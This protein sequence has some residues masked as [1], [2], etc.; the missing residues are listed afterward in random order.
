M[1]LIERLNQA[2]D[3][4]YDSKNAEINE[5]LTLPLD[6]RVA[7]GDSIADV[8]AEFIPTYIDQGTNRIHFNRVIVKCSRNISKYREGSPVVLSGHGCSFNLDVIEDNNE[9]MTLA[10]G[11]NFNSIQ[12]SLN[13]KSGW[14]IDNAK[15]DIRHIV[16]KATDILRFNTRTLDYISGIFSGKIIF[17]V[18]FTMCG[19]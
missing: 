2:I 7:K 9:Q 4:E 6:D 11:W 19:R 16:K 12:R 1:N 15:V 8:Q 17:M 14:Q 5:Q 10:V 3:I 13:N 18:I